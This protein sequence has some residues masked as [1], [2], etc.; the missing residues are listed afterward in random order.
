MILNVHFQRLICCFALCF[1]VCLPVCA[2][3]AGDGSDLQEEVD[4]PPSPSPVVVQA[5]ASDDLAEA[6]ASV[7]AGLREQGELDS[8][9]AV[10]VPLEEVET[11]IAPAYDLDNGQTAEPSGTLKAIL[12]KLI[13]PYNPVVVEYRYQNPN[14]SSYSYVREIQPDYVWFC[15]AGLFALLVFCTFRLG[16]GLLRRQ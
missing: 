14:S 10:S 1:L 4:S 12:V 8:I 9:R 11:G 13:G 7:L 15:S 6:L 2:T 16:G 3:D 5:P